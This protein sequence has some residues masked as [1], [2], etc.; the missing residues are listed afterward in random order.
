MNI[1]LDTHI[2]LWILADDSRLSKSARLLIEDA[3]NSLYISTASVWEISIKNSKRPDE[4]KT[5]AEEF[6]FFCNQASFISVPM[7]NN[8]FLN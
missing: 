6:S 2:A 7:N 1:L 3:A 8:H 4:M 5:T